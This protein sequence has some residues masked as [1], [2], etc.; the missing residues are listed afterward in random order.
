MSGAVVSARGLGRRY[1]RRWALR[2]CT[3]DVPAGSV[4]A[5]V[6][7]NGS[8]K[9]TLLHL[10][11]GLS[12]PTEGTVDVLGWSIRDQVELVRP[13]LGFVAQDHPLDRRFS[14]AETLKLGRK[15]N[16]RWDDDLARAWLARVDVPLS[17]RVGRLS[18]GQQ[19]QVALALALAKRPELL[20]LDEPAAALDPVARRQFM[21][22]LMLAAADG[23]LTVLLSSHDVAELQRVCDH[24]VVLAAGGVRLAAPI[25]DVLA[26]HRLL[27][28]PR[29]QRATLA[30]NQEV[31]DERHTER[32]T[33]LVVRGDHHVYDAHWDVSELGLEDIVLAHLARTTEHEQRRTA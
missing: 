18:G 20:V 19:A 30:G 14:V 26:S 10:V 5:L 16:P 11:A 17:S 8:G 12:L 6:G 3:L 9:T 21:Q 1:G 7:P 23:D 22:S 31:V 32:Q 4:T 13:R 27:R 24:V 25:D 15:L 28:G 29:V 2:G 33:T